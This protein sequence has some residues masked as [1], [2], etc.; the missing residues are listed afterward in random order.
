M[1]HVSSMSLAETFEHAEQALVGNDMPALSAAANKAKGILLGVGLNQEAE[2][3]MEI[4]TSSRDGKEAA[5]LQLLNELQ[6]YDRPLV[7]RAEWKIK[8]RMR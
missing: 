4:E 8:E 5:Y 1:V 3:A 6:E 2:C 7:D